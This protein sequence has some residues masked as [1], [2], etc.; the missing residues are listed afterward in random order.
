MQPFEAVK[1]LF[2]VPDSM[3]LAKILFLT[4]ILIHIIPVA[5]FH[6]NEDAGVRLED[7]VAL[8]NILVVASLQ[9]VNFGLDQLHQFLVFVEIGFWNNFD[10]NLLLS[11]LNDGQID[12]R[13]CPLTEFLADEVFFNCAM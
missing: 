2:E 11:V 1:H 8:H 12:F 10:S 5:V 9:N 6:Y 4:D 3:V 13:R 7:I